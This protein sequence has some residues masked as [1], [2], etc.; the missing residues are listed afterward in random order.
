MVDSEAQ[1]ED[2]L[3]A[4]LGDLKYVHRDDIRDRVTL[5]RNFRT[6][7]EALNRVRLTDGEFERRIAGI[8]A[9]DVFP[10]AGGHG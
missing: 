1:L 7:F 9:G 8:I 10:E 6:H 3:V 5:E 4:K 2:Q